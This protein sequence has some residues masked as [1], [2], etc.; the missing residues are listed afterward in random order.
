MKSREDKII[1]KGISAIIV[2]AMLILTIVLIVDIDRVCSVKSNTNTFSDNQVIVNYRS[3]FEMNALQHKLP[4]AKIYLSM[5]NMPELPQKEDIIV[6][7]VEVPEVEVI[8][9]EPTPVYIQ[10]T[11]DGQYPVATYVWNRLR[12]G[13]YSDYV[14]AGIMG[15]LMSET[16]GQTLSLDWQAWS[17]GSYYGIAQWS[18]KFFPEVIG[19]DLEGQVDFLL[20]NI[21]AEFNT[22]GYAYQKG[23]NYDKFLELTDASEAALA[24]AKCYERCNSAYYSVRETNAV[25]AY[26]FFVG[27]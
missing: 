11:D 17:G 25:K 14:C 8:I 10:K 21:K 9:E 24:F 4:T 2:L 23:F 26:D 16:G 15:N 3:L 13:G 22:F 12:E 6:E 27:E 19:K 5:I 1:S 20:S 18:K 7:E